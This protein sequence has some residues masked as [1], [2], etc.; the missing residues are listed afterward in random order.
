MTCQEVP[1]Q[2][3]DQSRLRIFGTNEPSH[4]SSHS[5]EYSD[6]ISERDKRALSG[7][8]QLREPTTVD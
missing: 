6:R 3:V 1:H 8:P 5:D 4:N 2:H 7:A